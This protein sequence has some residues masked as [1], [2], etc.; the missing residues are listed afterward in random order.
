M[1]TVK[2]SRHVA[3]CSSASPCSSVESWRISSEHHSGAANESL[4]W[5]RLVRC[6]LSH[7]REDL[8]ERFD[9]LISV[10]LALVTR[11]KAFRAPVPLGLQPWGRA[12]A[13]CR[14]GGPPWAC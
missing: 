6:Q 14:A 4:R 9:S 3:I 10:G 5:A 8:R 11:P 12:F 2:S 13:L 7:S 1:R